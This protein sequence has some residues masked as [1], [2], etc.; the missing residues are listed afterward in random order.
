MEL[1]RDVADD[2]L[3]SLSEGIR[4]VDRVSEESATRHSTA[5]AGRPPKKR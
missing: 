1:L 2:F 5:T 4:A 3:T